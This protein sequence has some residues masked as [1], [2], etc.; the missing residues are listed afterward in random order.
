MKEDGVRIGFT[1]GCFDCLHLGHLN[2]LIQAKNYCDILV[3][4]I[5]SDASVKKNKGVM[6]PIQ[7]EDTRA[8][9]LEAIEYVDYVVIFDE[10]TAVP[11]VKILRPDLIAKEGYTIS[12]WPEAQIVLSWGGKAIELK[13]YNDYSTSALLAKLGI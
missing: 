10:D 5:N 6:R 7:D 9:I 12:Q 11:V 8:G 2:S 1:N 3:V 13:R 4:G